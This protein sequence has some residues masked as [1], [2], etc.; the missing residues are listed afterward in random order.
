MEKHKKKNKN[1]AKMMAIKEEAMDPTL[2]TESDEMGGSFNELSPEINLSKQRKGATL[3]KQSVQQMLIEKNERMK[4]NKWKTLV[5]QYNHKK[6]VTYIPLPQIQSKGHISLIKESNKI[7]RSSTL[8]NP[9][10]QK[11]FEKEMKE[12]NLESFVK[13]TSSEKNI[14]VSETLKILNNLETS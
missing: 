13:K 7:K 1:K 14:K 2:E 9:K 11:D 3:L 8:D 4:E 5:E 12:D 10:N 6:F